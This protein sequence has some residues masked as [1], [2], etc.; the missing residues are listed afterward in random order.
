MT[1]SKNILLVEPEYYSKFPPLGLMKYS[2]YYKTNRQRV[3]L[4]RGIHS[5]DAIGFTPD[6]IHITSLYTYAWH[7]VHLALRWYRS[8]FPDALI[9]VGG[10]YATLQP[11][12]L[13]RVC[14]V[15]NAIIKG[16]LPYLDTV[17]PDYATLKEI[18]EWADWNK[19]ILFTSRGCIRRCSFCAV[20][21]MEGEFN[22]IITDISP[23]IL[24]QHKDLILWDNNLLADKEH[25]VSVLQQIADLGVRVEFNQ[26]L[27]ARLITPELAGM[28]AD[29]KHR[30]IHLAY[31]DAKMGVAVER[32]V[33]A[34]NDAGIRRDRIVI[35]HIY[36][37][38]DTPE[39]F[40]QRTRHILELGCTSYPMRYIPLNALFKDRYIAPGWTRAQLEMVATARRVMGSHGAF[41]PR[42]AIVEK[43]VRAKTFEEAFQLARHRVPEEQ[44]RLCE[45][46]K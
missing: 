26:G 39:L 41:P 18:P 34:L 45:R 31:D 29:C 44:G 40:L 42:K 8:Q 19:A 23:Y 32:A 7:P 5:A 38:G 25:A 46:E 15:Y 35:Y 28:I 36:N 4:V 14:P 20:S 9:F 10:I 21:Q 27:D 24:P 13:R 6:I 22:P 17:V 43:M 33:Q 3:K 12:M 16:P 2:A 37:Y 1:E 11:E 30:D